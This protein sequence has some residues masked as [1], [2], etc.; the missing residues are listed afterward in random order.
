MLQLSDKHYKFPT[1]TQNFNFALNFPKW[2]VT[3]SDFVFFGQKYS[4]KKIFRQSFN[5][6]TPSFHGVTGI[7]HP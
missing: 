5:S 6:P 3:A 2:G 1:G 4:D 7:L